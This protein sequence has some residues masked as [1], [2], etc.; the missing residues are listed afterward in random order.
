MKKT[1]AILILFSNILFAQ[2]AELWLTKTDQSVLF[3][4]QNKEL[5][6]Q[7][8]Q[9]N[10][11]TIF[12]NENQKFQTMDGFGYT[13]TSGSASLINQI[14]TKKELLNELFATDKNNIGI[15]YLRISIGASDLSAYEYSYSNEKDLSLRNFSLKEEEKA[16]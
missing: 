6:F 9:T 12:V 13:L 15:S 5:V 3:E 10:I 11:P 2:K 7:K 8:I 16:H 1:L 14:S 4:K